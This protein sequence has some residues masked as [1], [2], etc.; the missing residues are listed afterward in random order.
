MAN[1]VDRDAPRFD[2]TT[3]LAYERTHLA[4]Q[5]TMLAWVRTG[6]SLITFGFAI[7]SFP[8]IVAR[9]ASTSY[10]IGPHLL[11]LMMVVIGLIALLLATLEYRRNI[12]LL[13]V[14]YPDLPPSPL[15]AVLALLISTLG[16]V[17][18]IVILFRL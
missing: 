2:R 10:F 6:T 12:R 1:H 9:A 17:A 7:Y 5:R 14:Q 13:T 8:R 11:A 3:G 18:L 16:I 15:P 4:Y